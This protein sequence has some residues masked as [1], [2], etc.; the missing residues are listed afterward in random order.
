[1]ILIYRIIFQMNWKKL[2][3][4]NEYFNYVCYVIKLINTILF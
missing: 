1:M 4:Y 2:S 3:C